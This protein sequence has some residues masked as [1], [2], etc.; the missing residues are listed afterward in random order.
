MQSYR[1]EGFTGI[2][3]P[4]YDVMPNITPSW[5]DYGDYTIPTDVPI[6]ELSLSEA[7]Y[8]FN[9]MDINVGNVSM[10]ADNEPSTTGDLQGY[11]NSTDPNWP[12]V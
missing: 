5:Q 9:L 8:R 6:R 3:I 12:K 4:D 11:Q 10:V 1:T 2:Q 7:H